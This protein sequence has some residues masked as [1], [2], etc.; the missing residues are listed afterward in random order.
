[1]TEELDESSVQSVSADRII[2]VCKDSEK[3]IILSLLNQ[4][5]WK[6]RIQSI[7][8]ESKLTEW[9]EKALRGEHKGILGKRLLKELASEITNEFPCS[10]PTELVQFL[11][12]RKYDKVADKY[13]K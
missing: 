3:K 8:T 4:I 11:K 5:G 7:V 13:W 12:E 1:M 2:I 6:A 10:E 9:Y